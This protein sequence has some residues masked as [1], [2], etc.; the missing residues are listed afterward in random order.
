[1]HLGQSEGIIRTFTQHEIDVWG[2]T[3]LL[4]CMHIK[5]IVLLIQMGLCSY[6]FNELKNGY[7]GICPLLFQ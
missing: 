6:T 3:E 5:L 4:I 2:K 7:I 1:M